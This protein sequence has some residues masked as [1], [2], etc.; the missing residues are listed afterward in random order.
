[1]IEYLFSPVNTTL[2]MFAISIIVAS[3]YRHTLTVF[4]NNYLVAAFTAIAM[5]VTFI[6]LVQLHGMDSVFMM[7]ISVSFASFY[8]FAPSGT[9]ENLQKDF[10]TNQKLMALWYAFNAVIYV[11]NI[12]GVYYVSGEIPVAMLTITAALVASSIYILYVV[13]KKPKSVL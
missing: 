6:L 12:T 4:D 1:M 7:A 11:I 8:L 2:L 3:T 5:C 13:L 10:L 9:L